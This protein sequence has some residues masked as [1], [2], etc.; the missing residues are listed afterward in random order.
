MTE[1]SR[2]IVSILADL[3]VAATKARALPDIPEREILLSYLRRCE[4]EVHLFERAWLR[5]EKGRTA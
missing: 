2:T 1:R 4:V 3:T 5:H